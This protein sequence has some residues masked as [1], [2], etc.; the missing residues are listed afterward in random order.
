LPLRFFADTHDVADIDAAISPP[1]RLLLRHYFIDAA[2]TPLIFAIGCR[3]AMA[4]IA[5]GDYC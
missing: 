1:A 5:T 3:Y 4:A 2:A